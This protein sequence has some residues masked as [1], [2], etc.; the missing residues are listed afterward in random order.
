VAA[1]GG[2]SQSRLTLG[3][4]H[5]ALRAGAGDRGA[6]LVTVQF[7]QRSSLRDRSAEPRLFAVRRFTAELTLVDRAVVAARLESGGASDPLARIDLRMDGDGAAYSLDGQHYGRLETP[8]RL[9]DLQ[10]FERRLDAIALTDASV[11]PVERSQG[12]STV[13]DCDVDAHSFRALLALFRGDDSSGDDDAALR[14]FSIAL[15]AANDVA[16]DYWWSI[17]GEDEDDAGFAHTTACHVTLRV[18]PLAAAPQ[19]TP[20]TMSAQLPSLRHLDDV[21]AVLRAR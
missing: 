17:A 5:R 8:P 18:T 21:W 2:S 10:R 3:A 12:R 13:V 6:A 16:L 4:L 19:H 9:F 15:E 14:S 11:E 7:E 20:L 1:Q